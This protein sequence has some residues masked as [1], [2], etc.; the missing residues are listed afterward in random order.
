VALTSKALEKASPVTDAPATSKDHCMQQFNGAATTCGDKAPFHFS[1]LIAANHRKTPTPPS[2][3]TEEEKIPETVAIPYLATN[4]GDTDRK[5]IIHATGSI[6]TAS[7]KKALLGIKYSRSLIHAFTVFV[8]E[9]GALRGED[10]QSIAGNALAVSLSTDNNGNV[11]WNIVPMQDY[12]KI[13]VYEHKDTVAFYPYNTSK[14]TVAM[15]FS[16]AML[17]AEAKGDTRLRFGL[18]DNNCIMNSLE[19][20]NSVRP[21]DNQV[22]GCIPQI[23][24]RDLQLKGIVGNPIKVQ[25]NDLLRL[26]KLFSRMN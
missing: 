7:L 1:N 15:M 10:G 4:Y 6:K 18:L 3:V 8:F 13:A 16:N 5:K 22:R 23:T 19:I 2:L 24:A 20:L 9:K 14:E 17:L 26:E 11:Y 25:G 12:M 21:E